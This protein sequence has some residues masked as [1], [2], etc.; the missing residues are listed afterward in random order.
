MG[1]TKEAILQTALKLFA[2]DGYEAVSVS[3]IAG[4][5][6]MT[7]GALYRHYKSKRDIFDSILRRMEQDDAERARSYALPEGT[8]GEMEQ[9]YRSATAEQVIEFSR[10]QFRY[11][12][13][14]DFPAS[15]RRLLTLEQ[16]RSGEMGGLYRQ[17]L[18]SGPLDYTADLFAAMGMRDA[19]RRAVELCAPMLLFYGIYDG[20]PGP[21]AAGALDEYLAGL[22]ERWRGEDEAR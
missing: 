21:E 18:V 13:Q 20:A 4:E 16:Y 12:T 8:L 11:W 3:L 15:F 6:G 1:E 14:E 5:L 7:K 22:A 9:A 17:Y 10:A 19:R 2:K